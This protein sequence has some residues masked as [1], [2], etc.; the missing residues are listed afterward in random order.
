MPSITKHKPGAFCWFELATTNQADAKR[1]YQAL[2]GWTSED[3]P[4]GPDEFYTTFS[5]GAGAVG[6]ASTMRKEHQ[7]Q[8]MPPNWL[9]YIAVENADAGSL[10]VTRS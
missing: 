5:I 10:L 1:F 2:F 8:G 4:M 7:S 6:A 3:S 9:I